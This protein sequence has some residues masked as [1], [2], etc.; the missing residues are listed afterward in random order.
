MFEFACGKPFR[1]VK[2]FFE[3]EGAPVDPDTNRLLLYD[4]IRIEHR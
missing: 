2:D 4:S 1:V 3:V